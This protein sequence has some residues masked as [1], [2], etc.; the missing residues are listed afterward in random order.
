[1]STLKN[2]VSLI[3][4]LGKD[5]EVITFQ[6]GNTLTKFS[7]ATNES[8]KTKEGEWADKTQWHNII[9]WGKLGEKVAQELKK[10]NEIFL[11]GKLEN[12]SYT[13]KEGEKRY[14]TQINMREYLA[15][16]RAEN[17][18]PKK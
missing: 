7:L 10:G 17:T 2:T 12:E 14:I 3:G 8:Y 9:A 1:M 4:N 6:T 15:V 11:E 18:N 16:K 13:T 5:P